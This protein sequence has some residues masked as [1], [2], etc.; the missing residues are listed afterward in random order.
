MP[1]FNMIAGNVY[2]FG[3]AGIRPGAGMRRGTLGFFGDEGPP[4]LPTFRKATTYEPL[5]LQLAFRALRDSGF[6][7]PDDLFGASFDLYHGDFLEQGRGEIVV[8]ASNGQG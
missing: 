6:A 5:Y 8:R 2:V 3:N 7:V 4:L 1:G